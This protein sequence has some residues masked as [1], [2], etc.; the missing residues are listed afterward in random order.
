MSIA[1]GSIVIRCFHFSKTLA[2]WQQALNYV[3]REPPDDQGWAVLVD[4]SGVG[5]NLSFQQVAEP[6]TGKRGRLHMD[7]YA[8]DQLAEVERLVSLGASRYPWKYE[9]D[10]DYIVLADP[11]DNLFCVVSKDKSSWRCC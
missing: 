10:A 5:V 11:D 8:E 2:F 7:L 1:V 9:P 6:R 4:P 3:L